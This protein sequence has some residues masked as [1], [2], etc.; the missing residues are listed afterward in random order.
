MSRTSTNTGKLLI[1]EP[2]L[3]ALPSLAVAIGLKEAIT[4]QQLHYLLQNSD[5][6]KLIRGRKHIYNTYSKW[7]TY[8]PFWSEITIKRIFLSLEE[9]GLVK[10]IQADPNRYY[11]IKYYTIDYAK[12]DE[13][14]KSIPTHSPMKSSGSKTS[15]PSDQID[16]MEQIK[17]VSSTGS[18]RSSASV[19][20]EPMQGIEKIRCSKGADTTTDTTTDTT[21][22]NKATKRHQ[23]SQQIVA[24]AAV[25]DVST[26]VKN[27]PSS[28]SD[29]VD[30]L[31]M[32]DVN[33]MDAVR[34]A[35]EMPE[36]CYRQ[37]EYLPYVSTFRS[38][39]GA[40]LRSAI[41]G[42]YGAPKGYREAQQRAQNTHK[43]ARIQHLR[44]EVITSASPLP[45]HE[46]RLKAAREEAQA[47]AHK[48]QQITQEA[49]ERMP[50][51]IRE[52]PQHPTY[53]PTL[54]TCIDAVVAERAG[55][56]RHHE[57]DSIPG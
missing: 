26:Q 24:A 45:P 29:I 37:L 53:A 47:D 33:R 1:H 44:S 54:Q 34:L 8:F 35:A 27:T 3:Q 50:K 48:W 18:K 6:G 14:N 56:I 28:D 12:V 30:Q 15:V 55:L 49:K 9:K 21:A 2:P 13:I 41:E 43:R 11:R 36:E 42:S 57:A 31:I 22:D 23:Q 51:I 16:P 20:V 19:K 32:H 10:S 46:T 52:R 38:G 5:N 17:V 25:A 40:Y 7:K 39:K 4:L